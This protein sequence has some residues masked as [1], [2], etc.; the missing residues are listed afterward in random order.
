MSWVNPTG[1]VD[2]GGSWNTE[3]LAYDENTATYAYED[4]PAVGWGNYLE[5]TR[6]AVLCDKVQI[7]SSRSAA[8]VDTIAVDV[9]Y[10]AAWHNIYS[11]ALIIGAYQEYA[12]DSTQTVTAM[13]IRY[14][15]NKKNRQA[16][17]CEADFND[18]SAP[19]QTTQYLSG[20]NCPPYPFANNILSDKFP[21]P[22]PY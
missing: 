1:F 21:C 11:G 19:T 22:Q 12:I 3:P 13:R 8:N 18:V 6:A 14:S 15:T 17:I 2:G 4:I 10:G 5:L 20:N 9:Y 16:R 7:W